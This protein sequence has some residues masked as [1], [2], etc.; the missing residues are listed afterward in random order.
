M[1]D[2]CGHAQY[3]WNLAVEQQ[4]WYRP[5]AREA[6][7]HKDWVEKTSTSLARRHDLIRIEDLPIGHMTR[8]ARGIIAEPGRNVRQKAGL[9][10][11]IEATAPA[12]R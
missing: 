1:E 6:H 3:V 12:G 9:N 2:H 5:A 8:S 4:S 10:R 7:R 11:S